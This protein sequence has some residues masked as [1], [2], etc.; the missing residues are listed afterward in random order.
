MPTAVYMEEDV[1]DEVVTEESVKLDTADLTGR[2][3]IVLD[4]RHL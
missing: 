4:V 2:D 3:V 1:L